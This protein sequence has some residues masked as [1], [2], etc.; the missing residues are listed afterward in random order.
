MEQITNKYSI[1]FL[2]RV[3]ILVF[4]IYVGF[5][6]VTPVLAGQ[7]TG[8][9]YLNPSTDLDYSYNPA[10]HLSGPSGYQVYLIDLSSI[11][12]PESAPVLFGYL[13]GD[14]DDA[15]VVI[16]GKEESGDTFRQI[17]TITPE[18]NG[19]FVYTIPRNDEKLHYFQAIAIIDTETV[20]S[21][22]TPHY[23]SGAGTTTPVSYPTTSI[24][25]YTRAPTPVYTLAPTPVY[26]PVPQ[27]LSKYTTL[28]L[29]A[30]T[31]SPKVGDSVSLSGQ[32]T[33]S[34]GNGIA[35]ATIG[36]EV[37]DESGAPS[38][39]PLSTT[40]TDRDGRYR[41]SI[42]TWQPGTV[43]IHV[44]YKGD[45]SHLPATSNSLLISAHA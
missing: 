3:F 18:K 45:A 29:Q 13:Q 31:F 28:T 23:L 36:V 12:K 44:S 7:Q 11:F 24:P 33:D 42:S 20:F 4:L 2:S 32:L 6:T 22:I 39:T 41:T 40:R 14:Y 16:T 25:V 30:D 35:Q 38:S 21:D 8:Y 1:L 9:Q 10:D 34:S 27:A 19:L 37:P 17:G 43:A 26:T 15:M 5:F